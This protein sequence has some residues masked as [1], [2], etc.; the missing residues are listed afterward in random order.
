M[1]SDYGTTRQHAPIVA[2]QLPDDIHIV[3]V[4]DRGCRHTVSL[5]DASSVAFEQARM[6]RQL[7]AYRRQRH[8]P[9]WL[10][11]A[12]TKSHIAYESWLERHHVLEV[13][14]DPA[15]V[16]IASQ[17]LAMAWPARRGWRH[18]VP[19]LFCRTYTGAG[20]VIDCRPARKADA[21]FREK[22]EITQAVCEVLGWA[23][24]AVAEPDPVWAANLRWLAGYRHPRFSEPVL[25]T[26]LMEAYAQPR[27]LTQVAD[28]LGDLIHVLPVV[29]HLLWRGQL[30]ADLG[31]PL[32]DRTIVTACWDPLEE[33][34]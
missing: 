16:G 5:E 19:D 12:T 13:D 25:E 15:V 23:F 2:A 31:Q 20:V 7:P 18:H 11:T 4:D 6:I 26:L 21:D 17:A 27:P 32:Q 3:Y 34:A 14:R 24:R 22:C 29:Y 1:T 8:F 9:G 33:T 30:V 10:W 28:E